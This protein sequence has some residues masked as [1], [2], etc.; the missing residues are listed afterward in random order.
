MRFFSFISGGGLD[1]I[2]INDINYFINTVV[3]HFKW[4]PSELRGLF[5]DRDDIN[6]LL[7]WYDIVIEVKR[8]E[9]DSSKGRK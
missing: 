8:L 4:P 7:H 1:G 2:E 6:G 5:I 3:L 9:L